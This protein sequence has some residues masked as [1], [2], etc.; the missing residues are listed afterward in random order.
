MKDFVVMFPKD[1]ARIIKN[2]L[3]TARLVQ[4][5]GLLN[6]DLNTVRGIPPHLWEKNGTKIGVNLIK[7]Q[8]YNKM[9][10]LPLPRLSFIEKVFIFI[11]NAIK[12]S[13]FFKKLNDCCSFFSKK[14]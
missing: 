2:P 8:E 7:L 10:C 6:P 1:G 13:G 14:S 3:Q 12:A 11:S 5:G 4:M 9:K